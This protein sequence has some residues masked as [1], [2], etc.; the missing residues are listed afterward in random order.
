[1][2]TEEYIDRDLK[3]NNRRIIEKVPWNVTGRTE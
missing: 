2:R 1:M 3:G